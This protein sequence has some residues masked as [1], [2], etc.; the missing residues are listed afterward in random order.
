MQVVTALRQHLPATAEGPALGVAALRALSC[1]RR[2]L[3]QEHI[4]CRACCTDP[5]P[6]A[7]LLAEGSCPT[8]RAS[9]C[10]RIAVCMHQ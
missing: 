5:C 7:A 10:S 2:A 9:M 8:P 6:A 4:A 1:L 3:S